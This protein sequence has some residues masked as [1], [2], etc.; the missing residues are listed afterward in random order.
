MERKDWNLL[1]IAAALGQPLSPVQ[2]QKCL[3]I[4]GR[5]LP[6][7]VG[8]NYYEFI[9]YDYGPFAVEVYRDAEQL[10][11]QGLVAIQISSGQK[12][13]QYAATPAGMANAKRLKE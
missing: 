2:L 6:N 13:K 7:E 5:E 11:A 4:L 9:P 12:W 1:V 3:F 10:A 8:S